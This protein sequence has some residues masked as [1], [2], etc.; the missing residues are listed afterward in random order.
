MCNNINIQ[1]ISEF[2]AA[3]TNSI[4]DLDSIH[5]FVKTDTD[6]YIVMLEDRNNIDGEQDI[7][8]YDKYSCAVFS[9]R[10]LE[11]TRTQNCGETT[12]HQAA[13]AVRRAEENGDW[14]K[15]ER[16]AS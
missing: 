10:R 12:K 14:Y 1:S 5:Y 8:E 7:N 4:K 11:I 16:D 15:Y 3:Y 6:F 9:A 13:L 2:S